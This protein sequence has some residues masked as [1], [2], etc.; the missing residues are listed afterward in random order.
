[1]YYDDQ[2]FAYGAPGK[3]LI[4]K[5]MRCLNCP[6]CKTADE[7]AEERKK[8]QERLCKLRCILRDNES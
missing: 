4:L 7:L 1:M 8:A 6:F 5:Q 3:C 2:C